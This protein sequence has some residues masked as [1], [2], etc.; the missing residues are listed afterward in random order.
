VGRQPADEAV[1]AGL[2]GPVCR[3]R[4][5]RIG[6]VV[7]IATSEVA[8]VQWETEPRFSALVGQHGALTDDERLVPLLST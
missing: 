8:V 4:R 2:F 6:D 3:P 1:R 7:A 5:S